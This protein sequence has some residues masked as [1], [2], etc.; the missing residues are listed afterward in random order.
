M[1]MK[2]V[3]I[4]SPIVMAILSGC[5][6]GF[7]VTKVMNVYEATSTENFV[8]TNILVGGGCYV[9]R[10]LTVKPDGIDA[11]SGDE[12]RGLVMRWDG[13]IGIKPRSE[14][15]KNTKVHVKSFDKRE[16]CVPIVIPFVKVYFFSYDS[17]YQ[18]RFIVDGEKD[19]EY[20]YSCK[21]PDIQDLPIAFQRDRV[22]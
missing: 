5:V 16:S 11:I 7:P 20:I 1:S 3:V 13:E 12:V 4:I 6:I 21:N 8:A 19:V 10:T 15:L 17:Y 22:N 18:I 14:L 9:K 2:S